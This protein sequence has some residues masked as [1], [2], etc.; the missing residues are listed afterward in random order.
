MTLKNKFFLVILTIVFSSCSSNP[1]DK[2]PFIEGYWEI[3]EVQKDG[4]LKK[5]YNISMSIDYFKINDDLSG[6]RKKVTPTLEGTYI[7]TQDQA[8]FNLKI[9]HD[10][11]N[12]YYS[13]NDAITKETII[14]ATK[15]ELIIANPQGFR[16]IYKPYKSINI[17]E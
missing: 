13:Y 3:K 15:D 6:F 8:L 2:I 10:S 1:E 4:E 16:Y 17:V 12:M 11:L 14:K 9:E 5:E 7:V